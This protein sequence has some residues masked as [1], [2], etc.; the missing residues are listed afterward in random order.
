MCWGRVADAGVRLLEAQMVV[1]V[2]VLGRADGVDC[3]HLRRDSVAWTK[4]CVA[5]GGQPGVGIVVDKRGRV[6][7]SMFSEGVPDAVVAASGGEV[8]AR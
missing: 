2:T 8:V 3:I 1:A 7:E 6:L 4:P 5:D